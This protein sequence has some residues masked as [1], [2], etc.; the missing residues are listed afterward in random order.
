MRHLVRSDDRGTFLR[1]L[2]IAS[3]H[4][5][6]SAS[7]EGRRGQ[8]RPFLSDITGL[9]YNAEALFSLPAT[10]S[11]GDALRV[12]RPNEL[13]GRNVYV[14]EHKYLWGVICLN[15][16][17]HR[18]KEKS[19]LPPCCGLHRQEVGWWDELIR[20]EEVVSDLARERWPVPVR[21]RP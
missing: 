7:L 15:Q 10:D 14:A 18:I 13:R 9:G 3:V 11:E 8:S 5:K 16:S 4:L 12:S 20:A 6:P 17:L 1:Q 19:G 21:Q 2:A